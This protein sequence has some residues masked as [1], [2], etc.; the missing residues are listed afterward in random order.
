MENP[1]EAARTVELSSTASVGV[2]R[3]RVRARAGTRRST[4]PARSDEPSIFREELFDEEAATWGHAVEEEPGLLTLVLAALA[5]RDR[6]DCKTKDWHDLVSRL[7]DTDPTVE[8][9][10]AAMDVLHHCAAMP[11]RC[12]SCVAE[13][14]ETEDLLKRSP[15]LLEVSSRNTVGPTM[16]ALIAARYDQTGRYRTNLF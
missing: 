11:C 2:D 10:D 4:S 7:L 14:R 15:P 16:T 13:V 3:K 1:I 8:V 9:F 5:L 12:R 6:R